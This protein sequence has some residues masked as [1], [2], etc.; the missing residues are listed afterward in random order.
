MRTLFVIALALLPLLSPAAPAQLGPYPAVPRNFLFVVDASSNM[1][2]LAP[3]ARLAVAGLIANGAQGH[4]RRGDVFSVWLIQNTVITNAFSVERW[5]PEVSVAQA[6]TISKLLENVKHAGRANQDAAVTE[7]VNLARDVKDITVFLITD[8][9]DVLYGTPFDLPVS[10]IFIANSK[11]LIAE[12]RPFVTTLVARGGELRGWAVDAAGSTVNIPEMPEDKP[13]TPAPA[14]VVTPVVPKPKPVIVEKPSPPPVKPTPPK[15][16][17][18]KATPPVTK[19]QTSPPAPV[20]PTPKTEP[21]QPVPPPTPVKPAEIKPTETKPEPPKQPEV[22]PVQPAPLKTGGEAAVVPP[23][24]VV[25]SVQPQPAKPEPVK[26]EPV[27]EPVKVQPTET[28]V[29]KAAT[30]SKTTVDVVHVE[31]PEAKPLPTPQ[32]AVV[33]PP[34][35]GASGT[36]YLAYGIALVVIAIVLGIFIGRRQRLST[37]PSLISES[38]EREQGASAAPRRAKKD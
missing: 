17:P 7:I 13:P 15:V 32:A 12:K 30:D 35:P 4:M 28:P 29:S 5:L 37:G 24:K 16:E 36:A 27:P 11:Q 19:A 14:P 34:Q 10:T 26:I 31:T 9:S 1:K 23:A 21:V 2:R 22:K 3:A 25:V 20:Q 38:F 18:V 33:L 6:G 8:G